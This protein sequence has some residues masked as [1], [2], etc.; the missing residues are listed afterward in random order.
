MDKDC[1]DD[2]LSDDCLY[3]DD[4]FDED[5]WTKDDLEDSDNVFDWFFDDKDE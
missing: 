2:L 3:D 5:G 4:L 1:L